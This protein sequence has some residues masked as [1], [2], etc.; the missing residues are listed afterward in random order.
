MSLRFLRLII[1]MLLVLLVVLMDIVTQFVTSDPIHLPPVLEAVKSLAGP[2]LGVTVLLLV[3]GTVWL[4]L[5][6]NPA[7]VVRVWAA[8]RPPYPG[9]EAFTEQDA[10]VL[11]GRESQI[12]ELVD[13]LHPVMARSAHRFVA[14][15]G[16]SG[17]GKSSLVQAGLLARLTERRG[18]W[19]VVPPLLPGHHPIRSLAHSLAV[20]LPGSQAEMLAT[21]LTDE[22]SAALT[23]VA[24]TLRAQGGRVTPVLLVID[25]A[26]E[27]L[28]LTGARER[29]EFLEL[30]RCGLEQD[31]SL[32]VIATLRSEFLTG[33][34]QTGFADLF[35]HPVIIGTLDRAALVEVIEGPAAQ[36]GLQFAPGLVQRMVEDT[37][38]GDALPLLAYTLH[39]LYLRVGSVG[40]VT[41][42][43]YQQLGGS[44]VRSP[45]RPTKSVLSCASPIHTSP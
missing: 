30:L 11:F 8:S 31:P 45:G 35:Y 10:P 23:R 13:R 12:S 28:T 19:V 9:L 15:V 42:E 40:I 2:L 6:E 25:Q 14:V 20:L 33:F 44:L 36:V 29:A 34:L 17:V 38:G 26:E 22:G 16:P 3:G 4:Y 43:H 5:L 24:G 7:S 41:N 37:R 39:T 27:L 32:W 18:G 1:S 21:Q